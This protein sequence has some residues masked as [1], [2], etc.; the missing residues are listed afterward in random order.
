MLPLI[1]RHRLDAPLLQ[2]RGVV[3]SVGRFLAEAQA[4]A[5]VLPA[6]AYAFNCCEDRYNFTVGF[7]A[8]LL[9]G[10]TNLMP[11]SRAPELVRSIAE[12]YP[13]CYY[14]HDGQTG[15]PELASVH[16]RTDGAGARPADSIPAI[17]A[18]HLAALVFTSGS[19]G[20]PKP[21]RKNWGDLV[22]GTRLAAGCFLDELS[23]TPSV[24]GTVPPQHMYGL[25]TT[26]L[27]ALQGGAVVHSGRPL[28]PADVA[29]ALAELAPPRVFVTTPFHLRACVKSGLK[30]PQIAF[31]ISATAPLARELAAEAESGLGAPVREIYGCTEAGSLASR[32][33]VEGERWSMYPE[34][35]I[36]QAAEGPVMTGPQLPEAVPFQDVIEVFDAAHFALRGRSTDMLNIAGKRASMADLVHQLLSIPG[37]EDGVMLLPD[38]AGQAD[39]QHVSRLAAL[40]VAPTLTEQQILDTLRARLDPAFLPRPLY[41]VERL[42]RSEA[43]KLP[44]ARLLQMLQELSVRHG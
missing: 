38:E 23:G 8:V 14:L 21:N 6:R 9:R 27:F 41:K 24:L 33:T 31:V 36:A 12:D 37:V 1:A 40:V 43:S 22:A 30:F 35:Q 3:V 26:V 17:P 7:A 5:A 19:T 18:A 13:D 16:N 29:A 39:G 32:R 42:P 28:F 15:P 34:M 2:H 11:P 10:Q 20:K 4:L 44:R 25:E